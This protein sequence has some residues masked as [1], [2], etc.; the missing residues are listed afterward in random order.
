MSQEIL[1]KPV[2]PITG[3]TLTDLVKDDWH[4]F[5]IINFPGA[6]DMNQ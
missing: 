2:T 3:V 1:V 6:D 5:I 4:H